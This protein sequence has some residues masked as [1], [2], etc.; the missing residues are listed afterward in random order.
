M[1][2]NINKS[3]GPKWERLIPS[4]FALYNVLND[5]DEDVRIIAAKT[6]S[7]IF[8]TSLTAPAASEKFVPWLAKDWNISPLFIW[9]VLYRL[10]GSTTMIQYENPLRASFISA[11]KQFDLALRDNDTLFAEEEQNLFIDIVKD[12]KLW[13]KLV[14]S[15]PPKSFTADRLGHKQPGSSMILEFATWVVDAT[16]ILVASIS[17]DGPLGWTSKSHAFEVVFRTLRCSNVLLDYHSQNSA[18][19]SLARP[20]EQKELSLAVETIRFALR[21]FGEKAL[22]KDIHPELV[23][24]LGPQ[25][26]PTAVSSSAHNKISLAWKGRSGVDNQ[27][28]DKRELLEERRSIDAPSIATTSTTDPSIAPPHNPREEEEQ[29][30]LTLILR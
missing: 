12:A 6:C 23:R 25:Y 17:K 11:R 26:L 14:E 21:K 28:Q 1:F 2:G 18:K 3:P 4:L 19:L 7:N 20:E 30:N 24:E 29:T 8:E 13:S 15:I 16:Q 27:S 10:T 5:D 9:T 22:D